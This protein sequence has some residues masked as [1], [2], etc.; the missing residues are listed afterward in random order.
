ME[1]IR[2]LNHLRSTHQP[3]VATIGNFDGVHL[4]HQKILQALQHK[5]R[6]LGVP[7]VVI[8]F[9]P[10]AREFFPHAQTPARL[11]RLREK[12][13]L[14]HQF[15]IDRVLCLRFNSALSSLSPEQ[16]IQRVLVDGLAVKHL[17]V[18]DDFRF[19]KR[20]QGDFKQLEQA[21]LVHGFSVADTPTLEALDDGK[22]RRIS[23]SW[24]RTALASGQMEL[25]QSLLGRPYSMS[26][27]VVHGQKKGRTIGFPTANIQ[28]KRDVSPLFGVFAVQLH[29]I[30]DKPL[31]GVA[32]L[33]TR[34]TVNG[35]CLL[36]EVH[37]FD[38]SQDIY[39]Y[40][41]KVDFLHHIRVEKRFES[42]EQLKQQIVLDTQ[43]ARDFFVNC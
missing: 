7:A 11:T 2:S 1:F 35:S 15:G 30:T 22:S 4:G 38:F 25:A 36:L 29:G 32:N 6:E 31:A 12:L 18:G 24:V 37:L 16:F 8:I 14:F 23:S 10:Q 39:R 5:A 42:F 3:C 17:I 27:R 43:T 9:E 21:G 28:L 13:A 33:G 34:P 41:V 26:G 20:R 40:H 19:G